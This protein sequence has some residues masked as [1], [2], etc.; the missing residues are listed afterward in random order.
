[1]KNKMYGGGIAACAALWLCAGNA[2]AVVI[3]FDTLPNGTAVANKTAIGNQYADYHVSFTSSAPGGLPT[4][5]VFAGE[6]TSPPNVL[7]GVTPGQSGGLFTIEMDFVGAFAT[8]QVSATLISVGNAT[9]T[10]TAFAADGTTVI[11]AVDV[12]HGPGAG[13][14]LNNHDPITL[15]GKGIERVTFAITKTG[16]VPDGFGVDDISFVPAPLAVPEPASAL[17]LVAGGI[18]AVGYGRLRRRRTHG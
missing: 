14:G 5:G 16:A 11:D 10:A 8:S 12:T 18:A 7:Q 13:V 4:A 6:A 9:V 2:Q 1:M 15:K 17:A 3:N